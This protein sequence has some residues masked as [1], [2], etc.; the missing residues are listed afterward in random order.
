[1]PPRHYTAILRLSAAGN[2]P[3][4]TTKPSEFDLG[5]SGTSIEPAKM[6]LEVGFTSSRY[7]FCCCPAGFALGPNL[8]SA[9]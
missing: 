8:Q 5:G 2:K 6:V 9:L 7:A 1:M 4:D 3:L